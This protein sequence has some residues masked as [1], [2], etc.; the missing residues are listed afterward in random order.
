MNNISKKIA[1]E[2]VNEFIEKEFQKIKSF[3]YKKLWEHIEEGKMSVLELPFNKEIAILNG[4]I[5][6]DKGKTFI[7]RSEE[8][9]I[10]KAFDELQKVSTECLLEDIYKEPKE[11]L[12]RVEKSGV[13]K[14]SDKN[15]SMTDLLDEFAETFERLSKDDK[16]RIGEYATFMLELEVINEQIDLIREI[17]G[18]K[19][20]L[21]SL[22]E[23]KHKLL[24]R[25]KD[26]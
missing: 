24:K 1:K 10:A 16:E 3:T 2:Y 17:G 18:S 22:L 14:G 19:E 6:F 4:E 25:F 11:I 15:N 7:H 23:E 13:E 5:S 12:D 21:L 20:K 26:M 8:K 9:L